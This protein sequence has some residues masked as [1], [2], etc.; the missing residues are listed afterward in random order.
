MLVNNAGLIW[1]NMIYDPS[2]NNSHIVARGEWHQPK[3]YAD[4]MVQ[5]EIGTIEYKQTRYMP[6]FFQKKLM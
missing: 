5:N 4:F 2:T 6:N 1:V 3:A